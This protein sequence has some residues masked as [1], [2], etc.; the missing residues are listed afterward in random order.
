M[1]LFSNNYKKHKILNLSFKQIFRKN[2]KFMQLYQEKLINH[3][4]VLSTTAIPYNIQWLECSS[5]LKS[6]SNTSPTPA[7]FLLA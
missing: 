6:E 4:S 1:K 2:Q 5:D 3:W 7:A